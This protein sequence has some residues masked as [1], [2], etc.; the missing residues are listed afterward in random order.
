MPMKNF[1]MFFG[2]SVANSTKKNQMQSGNK[3]KA[4]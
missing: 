3:E 4:K 1:K 2:G